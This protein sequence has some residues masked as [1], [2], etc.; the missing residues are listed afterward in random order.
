MTTAYAADAGSLSSSDNPFQRPRLT[1]VPTGPSGAESPSTLVSGGLHGNWKIEALRTL[2][3]QA[4]T[5][6]YVDP[7][8]L[9]RLLEWMNTLPSGLP[10]PAVAIG[11][12]GSL[13]VEWDV[14]GNALHVSFHEG[15]DEVYF[16]GDNGEEWEAFHVLGLTK[17][18]TA[19]KRIMAAASGTPSE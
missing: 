11:E 5:G 6:A 2:V 13:F 7:D 3:S 19:L 16:S 12:E 10:R 9:L 8:S 1:L 17:L 15:G 4:R 14:A 18:V